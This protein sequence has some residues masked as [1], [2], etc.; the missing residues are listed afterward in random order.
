[1]TGKMREEKEPTR[2]VVLHAN[3]TTLALVDTEDA[4]R[5]AE[6]EWLVCIT[7]GGIKTGISLRAGTELCYLAHLV[8]DV[9]YHT[10]RIVFL[11]GNG[12]DCRKEN[13]RVE[14]RSEPIPHQSSFRRATIVPPTKERIREIP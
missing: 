8:M 1:M 2:R 5:V 6:H 11:N 4:F 14:E 3:P 10:H 7:E 13:L 9:D 12:L